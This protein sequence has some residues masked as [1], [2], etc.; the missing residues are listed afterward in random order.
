MEET[1]EDT[2]VLKVVHVCVAVLHAGLYNRT[3]VGL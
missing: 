1:D 2:V 3:H